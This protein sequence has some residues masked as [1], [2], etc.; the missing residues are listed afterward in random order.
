[1]DFE[2]IQPFLVNEIP[3][4]FDK[5]ESGRQKRDTSEK[6]TEL[7]ESLKKFTPDAM[8]KR[9]VDGKPYY[10][11]NIEG[12][13]FTQRIESVYCKNEGA[14]PVKDGLC[15]PAQYRP[16]CKTQDIQKRALAY[17]EESKKIF[18]DSF[19]FHAACI[20]VYQKPPFEISK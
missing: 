19:Y 11:V 1:M 20:C 2:K 6:S 13:N 9:V 10:I 5:I 15:L 4:D 18:V 7:C 12:T 3:A 14:K 16:V 8:A 17:D